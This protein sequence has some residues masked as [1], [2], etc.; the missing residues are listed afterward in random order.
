MTEGQIECPA[1][2]ILLALIDG[3]LSQ[4]ER[5]VIQRHVDSCQSCRDRIKTMQDDAG[6]L[7]DHFRSAEPSSPEEAARFTRLVMRNLERQ[8]RR[9]AGKLL[10]AAA[11]TILAVSTYGVLKSAAIPVLEFPSAGQF[12]IR[13]P[14]G[15]T[16]VR[17]SFL[18]TTIRQGSTKP[19][20]HVTQ[21]GFW[22]WQW[23]GR[24]NA[25][26]VGR[27]GQIEGLGSQANFQVLSEHRIALQVAR[28][29]IQIGGRTARAGQRVLL[30]LVPNE[31]PEVF[32]FS[33]RETSP[34]IWPREIVA[35][36]RRLTVTGAKPAEVEQLAE[37][38]L[39]HGYPDYVPD[40]LALLPESSHTPRMQAIAIV[41]KEIV[42]WDEQSEAIANRVLEAQ[43][44][45]EDETAEP[46]KRKLN[47]LPWLPAK[48]FMARRETV[49]AGQQQW[50][51]DLY[52]GWHDYMIASYACSVIYDPASRLY[53][54]WANEKLEN[55]GRFGLR[56]NP[57]FAALTEVRRVIAEQEHLDEVKRR[58]DAG[59]RE[60]RPFDP[61]RPPNLE[62]SV[63]AADAARLLNPDRGAVPWLIKAI[64][65]VQG[66]NH[67][68]LR[69]YIGE[70]KQQIEW[71]TDD[72]LRSPRGRMALHILAEAYGKL[73][74]G[75]F[76]RRL[77]LNYA[78][79]E[80]NPNLAEVRLWINVELKAQERLGFG[81]ERR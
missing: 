19:Q 52:D 49:V 42:T 62:P 30:I 59:K 22:S 12:A 34:E 2:E 80:M 81:R 26:V 31:E 24:A 66:P 60:G 54:K 25:F 13:D 39:L 21:A 35:L 61:P 29:A 9:P 71:M 55:V 18:G 48:T 69:K 4:S 63:Q 15:Q 11:I 57:A 73:E 8:R 65:R 16:M 46:P 64:N 27:K 43:K 37:S 67:P 36:Q 72:E 75:K 33:P 23:F 56:C 70:I 10:F 32:I 78:I 51:S 58:L 77:A 47:E 38:L 20:V 6:L 28:R 5:E 40:A 1:P 41:A 79:D 76:G 44:T 17:G 50:L 14:S 3:E 7:K 53:W 74:S 45:Q 68:D